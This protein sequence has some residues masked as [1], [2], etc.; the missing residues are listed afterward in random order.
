MPSDWHDLKEWLNEWSTKLKKNDPLFKGIGHKPTVDIVIEH[1]EA[2][3]RGE[4]PN[5]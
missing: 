1:M 5:D 4:D 3:E 2:I